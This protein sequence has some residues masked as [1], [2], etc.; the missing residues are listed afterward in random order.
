LDSVAEN[1][2]LWNEE[3]SSVPGDLLTIEDKI[4][5]KLA[6]VLEPNTSAGDI[7]TGTA[8]PTDNVDAYD[9]YLR[10][11]NVLRGLSMANC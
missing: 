6:E 9:S 2:V 3:F 5:G 11:N 7:A 4:C 1:K 8:H 10:G